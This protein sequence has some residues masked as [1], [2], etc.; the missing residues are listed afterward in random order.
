MVDLRVVAL[1]RE[2]SAGGPAEF[3]SGYLVADRLV[4]TACHVVGRAGAGETVQVD[5]GSR[6]VRG[7]TVWRASGTDGAMNPLDAAL[8]EIDDDHGP[9]VLPPVRWGYV[10]GRGTG[11]AC[12]ATGFPDALVGATGAA[13]PEQVRA[14]MMPL[15]RSRR[16]MLDLV[17]TSSPEPDP[18]GA[19]P[20]SGMSGAGVLSGSGQLLIAVIIESAANFAERRLT[21]VPVSLLAEEEG[22][23]ALVEQHSG[24]PPRLEPVE[25][26]DL[27]RPWY[28]ASRPQSPIALLRPEYEVAPFLGR[29]EALGRLVSWCADGAQVRGLLVHAAGG[30]GKTRL[31]RHLATRMYEQGWVVGELSDAARTTTSF[32]QLGRPL[33]LVVD[34]AESRAGAISDLLHH[35]AERPGQQ[36][37]RVLLLARSAGQWWERLLLDHVVASVL[38]DPPLELGGLEFQPYP[39]DGMVALSDAFGAALRQVPGYE[40]HRPPPAFRLPWGRSDAGTAH[41]LSL[42]IAVLAGML[43]SDGEPAE[44]VLLRHEKRHWNRLA[45]ERQ[46]GL[47]EIRDSALVFAL[48]CG[49]GSRQHA[50][51]TLTL[52]PG[53]R[54]DGAEDGRRALAHWIATLYPPVD[55]RAAYWGELAPDRL[56]EHL[57]TVTVREEPELL[58]NL[59]EVNAAGTASR[60]TRDQ[61]CRAV[62]VLTAAAAHPG[63]AAAVTRRRLMELVV[64]HNGVF[65]P[66]A[67]QVSGIALDP[68]PLLTALQ[69]LARH[70][71]AQLP[72]LFHLRRHLPPAAG[73]L[74]PVGL[75]L[76]QRIVSE[77]RA[78]AAEGDVRSRLAHELDVLGVYLVK[79][80]RAEEAVRASAESVGLLS[81]GST[82]RGALP[83]GYLRALTNHAANLGHAGLRS[84][85]HRV[86][87]KV[88]E[89]W[90]RP[91]PHHENPTVLAAALTSVYAYQKAAGEIEEAYRTVSRAVRLQ[92]RHLLDDRTDLWRLR[93]LGELL[94]GEA[95]CLEA[96]GRR[97]EEIAVRVECVEI[98][99]RLY[100][101]QP[102]VYADAF[103]VPARRLAVLLME[104]ERHA[105]AASL[106]GEAGEALERLWRTDADHQLMLGRT[107]TLQ[108][109]ELSRARAPF[110][111]VVHLLERSCLVLRD[112]FRHDPAIS[113]RHY[114]ELLKSFVQGAQVVAA[115]IEIGPYMAEV[116]EVY[117]YLVTTWEADG[118]IPD[119]ELT[120]PNL[121]MYVAWLLDGGDAQ[122]AIRLCERVE[123]LAAPDSHDAVVDRVVL[124]ATLSMLR[125]RALAISGDTRAAMPVGTAAAEQLAARA[126]PGNHWPAVVAAEGLGHLAARLAADGDPAASLALGAAGSAIGRRFV[127]DAGPAMAPVLVNLLTQTA[128]VLSRL[129]RHEQAAASLAEALGHVRGLDDPAA[130]P[131]DRFASFDVRDRPAGPTAQESLDQIL[132]RYVDELQ[133]SGD[134]A[135]LPAALAEHAE[136]RRARFAADRTADRAL[137]Y[138]WTSSLRARHLAE[139]SRMREALA[140]ARAAVAAVIDLDVTD[141]ATR[142]TRATILHEAA[143]VLMRGGAVGDALPAMSASVAAHRG[144]A[145][146]E[147]A[148]RDLA[149]S[150]GDLSSMLKVAGR[151]EESL[152]TGNTALRMWRRLAASGA[153]DDLD[154]LLM[155]LHNRMLSLYQAGYEQE[156]AELFDEYRSLLGSPGGQQTPGGPSPVTGAG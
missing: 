135:R 106:F 69:V 9:V 41:P 112:L 26:E 90:D 109:Q 72:Y 99:R 74:A 114:L 3:G 76:Q 80:G 4:L 64:V 155:A 78:G 73:V 104:D 117:D 49:A 146:D 156:A 1:R 35:L 13:E 134:S 43:A 5:L 62:V 152:T 102:G 17:P 86:A 30:T 124:R 149:A 52:L 7:R 95:D 153:A 45:T 131:N 125:A 70:P 33:L 47:P 136:L 148:H 31:A 130:D 83:A 140:A 51:Q 137:A 116:G 6:T 27:L 143:I 48:L 113:A 98:F 89:L 100:R 34:Y 119:D 123:R 126:T 39:A 120:V 147:D 10:V 55:P 91:G 11:V 108:A 28:P 42:H 29:T 12:S 87:R 71:A 96:L 151:V 46:V 38:P 121:A 154:G 8:V 133:R 44:Q 132:A 20:W 65:A 111:S 122:P 145:A 85:S 118:E 23:R 107:L 142:R 61:L 77:L 24:R 138:A 101:S 32:T 97:A 36:P 50:L 14:T 82:A 22:F 92:R 105:D 79:S 127:A 15:S 53:L 56:F 128:T 94:A 84:E 103:Q 67:C 19:S 25:L 150:L 75:S 115:D 2:G 40:Q 37:V 63:E 93:N 144:L 59:A 58:D 57:V 66:V 81:T 18:H 88:V 139:A 129:G 141:R 21:A 68:A 16:G 54:E 60:L 110:A